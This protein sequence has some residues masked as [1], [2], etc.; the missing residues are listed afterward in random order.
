MDTS[1][2]I[3]SKTKQ[4]KYIHLLLTARM[5]MASADKLAFGKFCLWKILILP[6][7]KFDLLKIIERTQI[8][9]LS[10]IQ[11]KGPTNLAIS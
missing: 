7:S 2:K 11:T 8:C 6:I 9:F 4:S 5:V 1:D 10:M 3:E